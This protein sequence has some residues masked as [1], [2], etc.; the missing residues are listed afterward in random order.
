MVII[1]FQAVLFALFTQVYAS[2]E[3][4]LP[5]DKWVRRMLRR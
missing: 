2:A 1:G 5:E 3:G 4:F